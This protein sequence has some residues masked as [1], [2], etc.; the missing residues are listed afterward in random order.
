MKKF[1][2]LAGFFCLAATVTNLHAQW[3]GP[4]GSIH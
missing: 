4:D 1:I 3:W 2:L